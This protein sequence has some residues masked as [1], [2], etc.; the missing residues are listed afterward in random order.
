MA[1][2]YVIRIS[3]S[4]IPLLL[5]IPLEKIYCGKVKMTLGCAIRPKNNFPKVSALKAVRSRIL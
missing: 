2:N 3:A 1:L 4:Y 5:D